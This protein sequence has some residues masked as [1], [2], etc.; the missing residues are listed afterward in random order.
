MHH[1]TALLSPQIVVPWRE[2]PLE[3]G[4]AYT[5]LIRCFLLGEP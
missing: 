5:P 2:R 3:M 4:Q 1:F